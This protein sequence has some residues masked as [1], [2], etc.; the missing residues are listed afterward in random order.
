MGT[1]IILRIYT[2]GGSG[3]P[4]ELD[5]YQMVWCETDS[6]LKRADKLKKGDRFRIIT[7]NYSET[8]ATVR[9][10]RRVVKP[11]RNRGSV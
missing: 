3:R 4:F 11:I 10:K 5:P 2:Y 9:L 1:K 7:S 6:A 8:T